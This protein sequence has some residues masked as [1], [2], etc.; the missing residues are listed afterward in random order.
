MKRG[1]NALA[2]HIRLCQPAQFAKA[3]MGLTFAIIKLS[4]CNKTFVVVSHGAVAWI[5]NSVMMCF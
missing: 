5:H 1:L 2:K 3:V 4:S